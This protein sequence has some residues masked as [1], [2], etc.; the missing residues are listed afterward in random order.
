MTQETAPV[1]TTIDYMT[2]QFN[3]PNI[4]IL[5]NLECGVTVETNSDDPG[6]IPQA[7][8]A[9]LRPNLAGKRIQD[10]PDCA[11]LV[12]NA[13]AAPGVRELGHHVRHAHLG[14]QVGRHRTAGHGERSHRAAASWRKTALDPGHRLLETSA[15]PATHAA[16]HLAKPNNHPDLADSLSLLPT[17]NP[18]VASLSP[19]RASTLTCQSRNSLRHE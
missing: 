2:H 8:S 4:A 17:Q 14:Q 12:A 1:I 3:L 13:A 5:R 10:D 9:T 18:N 16:R 7:M 15:R 19:A 11:D 6:S